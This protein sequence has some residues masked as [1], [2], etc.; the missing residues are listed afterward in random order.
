M[1][2]PKPK[3]EDLMPK[4][5]DLMKPE[6]EDLTFE[7]VLGLMAELNDWTDA[8]R[9]GGYDT[10]LLEGASAVC[11]SWMDRKMGVEE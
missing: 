9:H 3:S 1:T 5:E 2:E 8:R 10:R 7:K 6:W 4:F 11:R